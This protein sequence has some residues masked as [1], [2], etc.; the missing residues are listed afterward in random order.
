MEQWLAVSAPVTSS[1]G[2]GPWPSFNNTM[3]VV[4]HLQV[5]R[6]QRTVQRLEQS[7][8]ERITTPPILS[9]SSEEGET[10]TQA[11][12]SPILR[13]ATPLEY[14]DDTPPSVAPTPECCSPAPQERPFSVPPIDRAGNGGRPF[15]SFC[16]TPM[17]VANN[18]PPRTY[19]EEDCIF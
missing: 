5:P 11:P 8:L 13:P 7:L 1:F 6:T 9:S 14:M 18:V 19:T 12:P 17:A 3:M 15:S 4:D 2:Q 10:G 16:H